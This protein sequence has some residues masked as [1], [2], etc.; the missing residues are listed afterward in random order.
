MAEE[1]RIKVSLMEKFLYTYRS[2]QRAK[3][4]EKAY[5]SYAREEGKAEGKIETR[6]EIAQNMKSEGVSSE[7]IVR[8]TGLSEGEIAKL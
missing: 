2:Y 3:W 7:L 4:D 1:A 6:L 5:I 8:A